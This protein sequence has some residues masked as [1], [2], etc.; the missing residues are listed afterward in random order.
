MRSLEGNTAMAVS[1][2]QLAGRRIALA[3]EVSGDMARNSLLVDGG[4]PINSVPRQS[5]IR[6]T[7]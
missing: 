4:S 5:P 7:V 1:A 6:Q 2:D 3:N